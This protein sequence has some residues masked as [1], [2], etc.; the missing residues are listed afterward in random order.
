MES[1]PKNEVHLFWYR[2]SDHALME[3]LLL[4][5]DRTKASSYR[6]VDRRIEFETERGALRETLTRYLGP[7]NVTLLTTENGKPYLKDSDIFFNLSHSTNLILIGISRGRKIGVDV[8]ANREKYRWRE[9]ADRFF[10]PEEKSWLFAN[11]TPENFFHLWT[12]KESF[13]KLTGEGLDR[14]LSSFSVVGDNQNRLAWLSHIDCP[15]GFSAAIALEGLA[16]PSALRT[17]RSY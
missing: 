13:L 5:E 14:S 16:V 6:I 4:P 3:A 1:I 12:L 11:P 15:K 8:E 9:L 7:S 17:I 10:S 2:S